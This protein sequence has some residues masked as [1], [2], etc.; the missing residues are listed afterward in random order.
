[1][2]EKTANNSGND[3]TEDVISITTDNIDRFFNMTKDEVRRYFGDNYKI[4]GLG[5]GGFEYHHSEDTGLRFAWEDD[6][7]SFIFIWPPNNFNVN[8]A[9]VG[10]DF[11]QIQEHLGSAEIIETWIEHPENVAYK[12]E[13]IIGKCTYSFYSTEFDGNNSQLNITLNN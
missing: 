12:L 13:Y 3:Q 5:E 11:M 9:R 1:M 4:G 7:L 8:G 10:M 2:L 6:T